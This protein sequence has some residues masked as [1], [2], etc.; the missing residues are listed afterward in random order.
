VNY[1]DRSSIVVLLRPSQPARQISVNSLSP[2]VAQN[3]AGSFEHIAGQWVRVRTSGS[4][5]RALDALRSD[6]AV[7]HAS[8]ERI[9]AAHG[10]SSYT[11][12]S[13]DPGF[14]RYQEYLRATMD[15]PQAWR[16]SSGR[17]VRVAIIDTGVDRSHED[18]GRVLRGRDFVDDDRVAN[19]P[20]GHG[21][22]VA[23]VVAAKRS[24]GK[25][26]AGASRASILPVRVLTARGYARDSDVAR[27]IR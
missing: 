18:L 26:I 24:N 17:G 6:S 19:D 3:I 4:P 5:Q 13:D 25:G 21:T 20:N 12:R 7:A 8:F 14:D 16:R 2:V 1:V 27:G 9:R 22:F 15:F 11:M 23:G 10:L